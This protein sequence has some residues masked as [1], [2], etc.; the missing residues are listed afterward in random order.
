MTRS[1]MANPPGSVA[2]VVEVDDVEDVG[3]VGMEEDEG[4]D[5]GFVVGVLGAR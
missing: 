4:W 5:G 3:R 2:R 1:L